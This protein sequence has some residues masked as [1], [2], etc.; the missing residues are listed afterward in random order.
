[1]STTAEKIEVMSWHNSGGKVM[2]RCR[3]AEQILSGVWYDI[4][5][6]DWD[7]ANSDYRKKP[8]PIECW[9]RVIGNRPATVFSSP[10]D[11]YECLSHDGDWTVRKFIEVIE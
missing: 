2:V 6:P 9:C 1:M 4:S 7:W 10:E 8:E 11:A 3:G 5:A